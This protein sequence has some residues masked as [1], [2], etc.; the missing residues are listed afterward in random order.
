[1]GL[2]VMSLE[3]DVKCHKTQTMFPTKSCL[4]LI[5]KS[6]CVLLKLPEVFKIYPF[7]LMAWFTQTSG[8]EHFEY[9]CTQIILLTLDPVLPIYLQHQLPNY[10]WLSHILEK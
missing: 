6:P 4:S 9:N 10:Q 7:K 3:M 1:M 2:N 5:S 8:A